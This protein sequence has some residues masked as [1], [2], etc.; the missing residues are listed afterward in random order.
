MKTDKKYFNFPICLLKDFMNE[1]ETKNCLT[2]ICDYAI[3]CHAQKL[4]NGD[5]LS[6][7][8]STCNFFALTLGSINKSQKNGRELF[9]SIDERTPK[10]GINLDIFWDFFKN[11]KTEFDKVCL[12]GHLA[13]KS[14]VQNHAYAKIDN[15]YWLSRMSGISKCVDAS[16]FPKEI[17]KYNNHYQTRK[18]KA[19]LRNNW[20][21]ITYSMKNRGFYV[22]YK[23]TLDQLVLEGL[24]RKKATKD[25]QYKKALNEAIKNA[26]KSLGNE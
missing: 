6:R 10:V 26:K 22:S 3:Y 24:K 11:E 2:N 15:Q 5:E 25:E 20:G 19:E 17:R 7:I 9:N 23:I 14:I 4:E 21:L 16:Q 13:I 18:I 12:L 8:K 1:S